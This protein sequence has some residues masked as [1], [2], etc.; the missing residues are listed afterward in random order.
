[1]N[2]NS[3][4][5][6]KSDIPPRD[7]ERDLF[8]ESMKAKWMEDIRNSKKAQAYFEKINPCNKDSFIED[9]VKQKIWIIRSHEY[10]N[11]F[12][13]RHEYTDLY[14]RQKAEDALQ[15]ILQK[16]LFNLQAQWRANQIKIEGVDICSDFVFWEY[17]IESCPFIEPV[18]YREKEIMKEYL[19][20]GEGFDDESWY[21]W[22]DY[23]D[24]T[25]KNADGLPENM[26]DWY[27]WYD[28]RIGTGM[29]LLLPDL[30]GEREALYMTLFHHKMAANRPPPPPSPPRHPGPCLTAYGDDFFNFAEV[31]ES[32]KY[33]LEAIKGYRSHYQEE[34]KIASPN[35]I[36]DAVA[37][38]LEA[39]RPLHLSSHLNWDEALLEA[40]H[41]YENIKT[42]EALDA[43]YEQYMMLHELG[44]ASGHTAQEIA[45]IYREDK[46]IQFMRDAIL[47]GRE[48]N[49][50]PRDFN[51]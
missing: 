9:Y 22:Q 36:R 13:H 48:E 33:I 5:F 49:G 1:M 16:K 3:S 14:Y 15:A 34:L 42:A 6:S 47:T 38:L 17:H 29:L 35:R 32:D 51:Y 2:N 11:D 31:Y 7:K 25:A 50:E 27:E 43:A 37:T 46:H 26:P 21:S 10:Y 40:G 30:K 23:E 41:K 24:L 19:L 39:D 18:Q 8:F 4:G 44:M 20:H 28:G 45:K 12:Y